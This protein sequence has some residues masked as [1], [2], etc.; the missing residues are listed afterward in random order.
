MEYAANIVG[1]VAGLCSMVSFV[2]QIVKILRERDAS[3]VSL[4]MYMVTVTG[5]T[6]WT[7]YGVLLKSWPVMVSNG[8]CLGLTTTILLLRWRYGTDSPGSGGG[9]ATAGAASGS[10]SPN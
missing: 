4:R 10:G 3:A 9:A 5:F 7:V 2:P 8:V 6:L 1:T